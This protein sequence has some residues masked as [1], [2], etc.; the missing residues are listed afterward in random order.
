MKSCSLHLH[1]QAKNNKTMK[2]QVFMT[3]SGTN[4]EMLWTMV[5]VTCSHMHIIQGEKDWLMLRNKKTDYPPSPKKKTK[6]KTKTW[7]AVLFHDH[8]TVSNSVFWESLENS[9]F[10]FCIALLPLFTMATDTNVSKDCLRRGLKKFI[11]AFEITGQ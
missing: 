4:S 6:T 9:V 10:Q 11:S 3:N 8:R 7:R 5:S 2:Y 1:K